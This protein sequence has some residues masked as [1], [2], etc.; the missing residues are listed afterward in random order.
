MAKKCPTSIF[1]DAIDGYAQLP[2]AI[3][4]MAIDECYDNSQRSA[5]INIELT[6]GAGVQGEYSNVKERLDALE[7]CCD[8]DGGGGGGGIVEC[9]D[10]QGTTDAG[11]VTTNGVIIGRVASTAILSNVKVMRENLSLLN[12]YN[13]IVVGPFGIDS[14]VSLTIPAGSTFVVV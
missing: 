3:E 10:L 1:P 2:M 9:C 8:D 4:G 12:E 13:G 11:N 14:G 6:L 7:E 5:I